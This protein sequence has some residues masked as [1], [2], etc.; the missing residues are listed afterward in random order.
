MR[1]MVAH[2]NCPALIDCFQIAWKSKNY[3]KCKSLNFE[4]NISI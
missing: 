4:K 2:L 1:L 3:C